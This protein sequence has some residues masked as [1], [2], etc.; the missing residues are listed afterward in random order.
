MTW[1]R[2]AHRQINAAGRNAFMEYQVPQAVITPAGRRLIR[3]ETDRGV[4]MICDTRM[5]T[6]P[7]GVASQPAADEAPVSSVS[8]ALHADVA[9]RATEPRPNQGRAGRTP[10]TS[11]LSICA[12][13]FRLAQ[14]LGS[15]AAPGRCAA[16]KHA[17]GFRI[18]ERA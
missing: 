16:G 2:G 5:A 1:Y 9:P 7:Y 4:L 8:L 18:G 3:D 12:G 14:L 17:T 10:L 13:R 11:L 15:A 6:K